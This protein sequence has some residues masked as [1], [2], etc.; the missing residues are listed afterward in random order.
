MEKENKTEE[1][2]TIESVT[3]LLESI[4]GVFKLYSKKNSKALNNKLKKK[5]GGFITGLELIYR[6][7]KLE[8]AI[9]IHVINAHITSLQE[10]AD[11]R[12]FNS[13]NSNDDTEEKEQIQ[14]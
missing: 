9:M 6:G 5:A 14:Q 13:L 7:A 8:K 12:L 2:I 10:N 4:L 11:K 1:V 3:E